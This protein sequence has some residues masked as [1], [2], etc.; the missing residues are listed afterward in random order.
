[1]SAGSDVK[2]NTNRS[3]K[4]RKEEKNPVFVI[5]LVLEGV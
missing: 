3:V 2:S 1:M 4:D 5:K